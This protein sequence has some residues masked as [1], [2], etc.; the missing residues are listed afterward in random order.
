MQAVAAHSGPPDVVVAHSVGAAAAALAASWGLIASRYVFIA[1]A[2]NPAEWAHAFGDMLRLSPAVMDRMRARSERR[3]QFNWDDL[4][5]RVHARR[6][7]SPLLVIHDRDD[8]TVPITNGVDIV[9]SWPGARLVE[10]TGL[11]HSNILRDPS[12]IA[13]V[14]GFVA[15]GRTHES[16]EAGVRSDTPG[17]VPPSPVIP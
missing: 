9:R 7:T 17:N 10:T 2:A 4:D 8:T 1:P 11:G 14:T 16:R 13:R 6:M 5:A 15:D 3:L 12:V